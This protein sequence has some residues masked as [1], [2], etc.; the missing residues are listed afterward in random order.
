MDGDNIIRFC[1]ALFNYDDNDDGNKLVE[2]G[3][4]A[5]EKSEDGRRIVPDTYAVLTKVISCYAK[6]T[7]WNSDEALRGEVVT[8]LLSSSEF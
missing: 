3:T 1:V 8:L 4:G 5:D 2:G 6:S 7:L